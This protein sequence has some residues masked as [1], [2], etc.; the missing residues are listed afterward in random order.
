MYISKLTLYNFRSFKGKHELNFKSGKNFIVGNNNVGKT[1]IF[2]AIEFLCKGSNSQSKALDN[3]CSNDPDL[4]MYVELAIK[5]LSSDPSIQQHS[6][7]KKAF[8]RFINK[9]DTIIYR[10]E[11]TKSGHTRLGIKNAKDDFEYDFTSLVLID[12]FILYADDHNENY[13]NFHLSSLLSDMIIKKKGHY[14]INAKENYLDDVQS[15]DFLFK[16]RIRNKLEHVEKDIE[17]KLKQEFSNVKIKF[18][19]KI[20]NLEEIIKNGKVLITDTNGEQNITEK[21]VGVQRAFAISV[22]QAYV[23]C[24]SFKTR[25]QFGIDEPELFLH[26]IAQNK[27]LDSLTKISKQGTQIFLTT[28]SPYILQHFDPKIDSI[29]ILN[30]SANYDR[31]QQIEDLIFDPISV[32]E[33][34]YRAFHIPSIDFHQRLFTRL[35]LY[36]IENIQSDEK[37][38]LLNRMYSLED[39][40]SLKN[41]DRYLQNQGAAKTVFEPRYKGVWGDKEYDSLPYIVRNEID[42]PET[43]EKG[44]NSNTGKVLFTKLLGQSTSELIKIYNQVY[45]TNMPTSR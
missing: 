34:S 45:K 17:K 39:D 36:W 23:L 40:K 12:P 31:V 41:F 28:H 1:T 44:H 26:P 35:Y 19:F 16:E 27:L 25:T 2:K 15:A 14:L 32:G 18:D 42:H 22:L 4:D 33:I 21:G 20:P 11:Y 43:L 8:A 5:G 30:N 7:T 10:R 29:I 6:V 3:I 9:D 37:T 13:Y 38:K 24:N